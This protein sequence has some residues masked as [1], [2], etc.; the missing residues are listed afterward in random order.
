MRPDE[1][2]NTVNQYDT[3][4]LTGSA[5]TSSWSLSYDGSDN[6]S[7]DGTRFFNHDTRNRL[8][9]IAEPGQTTT[10]QY[11]VI[12]RRI[13]KSLNSGASWTGYVHAGGMEISEVNATGQVLV[14]YVPGPGIDQRE[15][16]PALGRAGQA[17][18]GG[19]SPTRP[20]A[21]R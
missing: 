3:V 5:G 4:S 12:G 21:R 19:S 6:L 15:T 17:R 20:R 10:Y 7:G 11:D 18:P 14:R 8:T 13:G 9:G 16:M 2:T 1:P